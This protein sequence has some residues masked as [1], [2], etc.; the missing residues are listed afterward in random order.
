MK[1]F[2]IGL[3]IVVGVVLIGVVIIVGIRNNLIA[4]EEQVDTEWATVDT[5]LQRRYD[6]I[7][8]LVSTV[9]GYASHESEVFTNIADARAA[10]MG[11]RSIEEKASASATLESAIGR[12]FAIAENY[13]DLKAST[14]FMNLQYELAGT[15]NRIQVARK[16]YNDSVRAFNTKIKQFPGSLFGFSPKEYFQ[17]PAGAAI[18]TAPEVNFN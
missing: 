1:N 6:L 14:N 17:P 18:N 11:A 9:K 8:N 5:Q 13:P 7:P 4:L 16:R 12:L 10:M 15:E 2:L 3:A